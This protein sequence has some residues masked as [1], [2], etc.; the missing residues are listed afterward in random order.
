MRDKKVISTEQK[1][2]IKGLM[3]QH[4]YPSILRSEKG[5]ALV[6][7]LVLSL[8][9]L[10]IISTLVYMV[11]QGTRFSGYYKRYETA[12]EAA[13]GGAEL[14]GDLILKRGEMV[15]PGLVN[16]PDVC[17]CGD[18]DDPTDNL[19]G[20]APSCFCDKLCDKTFTYPGPVLNWVNCDTADTT[21]DP[22]TNP[23]IQF[24]LAG[25]NARY[26]VSVKIVDIIG[27][28]SDLSGEQLGG[29]GVVSSNTG[30]ITAPPIPYLYRVEINSEDIVNQLE[31]ARIS[32]LYAY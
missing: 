11:I 23:D 10:S 21:F 30:M 31:R 22:T 26:R 5:L 12:R 29:T 27:G 20:G 14:G 8:I 7:V 16:M 28:N 18:L 4:S 9:T 3:R 13:L 24:D 32:A 2:L 25:V 17:D 6:T 1:V 19:Y 15:I